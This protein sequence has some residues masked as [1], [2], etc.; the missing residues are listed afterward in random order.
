M[1]RKCRPTVK[2]HSS[3]ENDQLPLRD[4]PRKGIYE[5]YTTTITG[6]ECNCDLCQSVP[7]KIGGCKWSQ[8]VVGE[9]SNKTLAFLGSTCASP[10]PTIPHPPPAT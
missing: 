9:Y 1:G 5:E 2:Q 7:Y 6:Q 8:R 4:W 3:L 10:K